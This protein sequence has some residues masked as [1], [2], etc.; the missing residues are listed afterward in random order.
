MTRVP[1][2]GREGGHLHEGVGP[3]LEDHRDE[4]DGAA[5]LPEA[6]ALV[7]A[8][9]RE[10]AAYRVG[11]GPQRLEARLSRA[12]AF[13]AS[14]RSRLSRGAARARRAPRRRG[15]PRWPPR[16]S[17][18][19]ELRAAAMASRALSLVAEPRPSEASAAAFRAR[20][21]HFVVMGHGIKR[22]ARAA[23]A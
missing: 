1:A 9:R 7:E 18:A 20:P 4:A 11:K 16:C 13:A 15:R 3:R 2:L 5:H 14:K 17:R 6:Q 12:R 22:M 19:P 21:S 10:D 8:A 23:M